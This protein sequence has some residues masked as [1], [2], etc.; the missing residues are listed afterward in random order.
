MSG[1]VSIV[2]VPLVDPD[3]WKKW[4][5]EESLSPSLDRD[6]HSEGPHQLSSSSRRA[7]GQAVS[8][9]EEEEASGN[10]AEL[11]VGRLRRIRDSPEE[12]RDQRMQP[13]SQPWR[14]TVQKGVISR[15]HA[16]VEYYF[17]VI[18]SGITPDNAAYKKI[19]YAL[20]KLRSS[21]CKQGR[22]YHGKDKGWWSTQLNEIYPTW[23][24]DTALDGDAAG[25]RDEDRFQAA[26]ELVQ[27]LKSIRDASEEER[28]RRTKKK[29][30]NGNIHVKDGLIRTVQ[31]LAE[32]CFD[33][34]DARGRVPE[35][36]VYVFIG[37]SLHYVKSSLAK[38]KKYLGRDEEWW[39]EEMTDIVYN[40]G[41]AEESAMRFAQRV[42]SIWTAS[43]EER[44]KRVKKKMHGGKIISSDGVITELQSRAEYYFGE[45][46]DGAV[47]DNAE[48]MNIGQSLRTFR[49]RLSRNEAVFGKDKKW[50][51]DEMGE[52]YSRVYDSVSNMEFLDEQAEN[53]V[54]RLK[55]I[56]TASDEE[57]EKR[58]KK[59]EEPSGIV[60]RDGVIVDL[61]HGVK[62]YFGK[63]ERGNVP[64]DAQYV[65]IGRSFC[66]L[67]KCAFKNGTYLGK[68][69]EWWNTKMKGIY[70][71]WGEEIKN[72]ERIQSAEELVKRLVF[73][74]DASEEEREKRTKRKCSSK[75]IVRNGLIT[76]LQ[77]CT[78]YYFGELENGNVPD[79]ALYMNIGRSLVNMKV[80]IQSNGRHYD[81]DRE[82]WATRMRQIYPS[83]VENL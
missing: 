26:Q 12:E 6:F 27:R 17:G 22:T 1:I 41:G 25:Q 36:G 52:M 83:W 15:I 35:T 16:N 29:K 39:N 47:P 31:N 24:E 53:L 44:D 78:Q 54:E 28:S 11:L 71:Q 34:L 81:R 50:W 37:K 40:W 9:E 77:T 63:L 65:N 67:K 55:R 7:S 66:S 62:Y 82:W 18:E 5:E 14:I 4:Q 45:L 79:K 8:V 60:V 46:D 33:D 56:V 68:D 19:G 61:E 2:W 20:S 70:H 72:I 30:R 64:D 3:N 42:K 69:K 58:T 51:R 57:R 13:R 48:Y 49:R 80:Y 38:N 10:P 75:V 32:Y 43:E 21:V 59:D 73:I 76:E 74:R 23:G